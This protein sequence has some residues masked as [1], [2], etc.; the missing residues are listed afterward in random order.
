MRKIIY[1]CCIAFSALPFNPKWVLSAE[2]SAEPPSGAE[3]ITLERALETALQ[4]N[5][6]L[7]AKENE[8]S[9]RAAGI[10]Q[11]GLLPNPELSY[12]LENFGGENEFSGLRSQEQTLSL[13][14]T[15]ELGGKRG[16]RIRLAKQELGAAGL[17]YDSAA[18]ELVSGVKGAFYSLLA[19]Q[20]LDSLAHEKVR[21]A[22]E[23]YRTIGKRVEAGK[24]SPVELS[25]A[26]IV[27]SMADIESGRAAAALTSARQNLAAACG[28][29]ELL[30]WLAVGDFETV[31]PP[32]KLDD[33]LSRLESSPAI[34]IARQKEAAN[35]AVEKLAR[36]QRIPDLELRGGVRDAREADSRGFV[37]E[38]GFPL[39]LFDRNQGKI[40]AAEQSAA[41]AGHELNHTRA[42]LT[43]ELTTTYEEL[44]AAHREAQA[45]RERVVKSAESVFR[46]VRI[47]Y[48][49][50]KFGYLELLDSQRSLFE[51]RGNYIETLT[52]CHLARAELN[53]ILGE[54]EI[55][56]RNKRS[57]GNR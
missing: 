10:K 40:K 55:P 19:A 9:I 30:P 12:E 41:Q 36:A 57:G 15:I 11:A 45:L 39:P 43:A 35:R 33:L 14:Q 49:E 17:E 22:H 18:Q 1:F 47:G 51:V 46:S 21:L 3:Q 48:T 37:A 2:A 52:R 42:E 50:G 4:S 26:E 32:D 53:R 31:E 25:R 8:I 20:R 24:V 7:A 56:G 13:G 6:W 5:Q 27:L 44:A 29:A 34:L 54:N 38:I 28:S 16:K 23:V